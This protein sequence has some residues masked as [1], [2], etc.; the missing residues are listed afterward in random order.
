MDPA[1]LDRRRPVWDAL[2]DVFL[3]TETRWGFPRI[4]SVLVASGYDEATLERI[5]RYEVFPEFRSNL[6]S[7]AGEWAAFILDEPSL[8]RR[9][10]RGE[11]A[12]G[13]ANYWL[14]AGILDT[15]WQG[16]LQLARILRGLPTEARAAH[17]TLWTALSHPY[18][19][20]TLATVLFLESHQE[21]VKALGWTREQVLDSFERHFRPVYRTLLLPGQDEAQHARNIEAFLAPV[22]G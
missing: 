8:A 3:D 7:V 9:A 2:S 5:W 22:F 13:R 15:Q 6:D 4:A 12:T 20:E 14:R 17:V 18:V 21:R 11:T 1:E 19:D 10:A 16:I